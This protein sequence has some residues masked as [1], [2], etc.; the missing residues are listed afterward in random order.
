MTDNAW[1]RVSEECGVSTY[2][3]RVD[4][5]W[6]YR[7]TTSNPAGMALAFA[8][9]ASVTGTGSATMP[10]AAASD[11]AASTAGDQATEHMPR[12]DD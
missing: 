11:D 9:A 6:L 10:S 2:R 1:E 12:L 7:V 4:N 3:M 8:Q 5:G